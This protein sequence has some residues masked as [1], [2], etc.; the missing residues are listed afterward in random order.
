VEAV[1]SF[2]IATPLHLLLKKDIKYLWSSKQETAFQALKEKLTTAPILAYPN[3]SQE[4]LLFTDALGIA[5][6][7]ILS[8][9]DLQGR[10]RVISY[11]SRSMSS[12]ERYYSVTEQEC[13]AIIWSVSHFRQYLH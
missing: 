9:R 13:L 7:T 2:P 10:E 4:F 6:G 8:Q 12:A 5:L 11:A 1:R 3:F